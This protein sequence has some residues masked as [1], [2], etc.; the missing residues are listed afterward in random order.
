MKNKPEFYFAS[1][2]LNP[3]FEYGI[4]GFKIYIG[5]IKEMGKDIVW[6]VYTPW[7]SFGYAW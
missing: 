4:M 7:F 3:D 6:N 5:K 2:F 1:Y